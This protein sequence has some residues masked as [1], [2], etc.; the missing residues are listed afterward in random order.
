M[1][2]E[3]LLQQKFENILNEI[4]DLI[5]TGKIDEKDITV[6]NFKNKKLRVSPYRIILEF[7]F[8]LDN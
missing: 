8:P 7:R 6:L 1:I 2:S 4:R 5:K 3:K